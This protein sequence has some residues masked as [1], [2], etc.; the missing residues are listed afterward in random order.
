MMKKNTTLRGMLAAT[1]LTGA[2]LCADEIGHRHVIFGPDTSLDTLKIVSNVERQSHQRDGDGLLVTVVPGPKSTPTL[3]VAPREG[4]WDL[5]AFGHIEAVITN[6]DQEN[7]LRIEMRV[8][9]EGDWREKPWNTEP[10]RVL[11]GKTM[12]VKVI[13]GHQYGFN[14][15]FKLNP[16]AISKIAL[17]IEHP[18]ATRSYRIE[19]IIAGGPAGEVP[20]VD[21]RS[22]RHI[23]P[24][25][26]LL[27]GGG[28]TVN[29]EKQI[30][31]QGNVA[32]ILEK[33]DG[34]QKLEVA[35]DGNGAKSSFV[36]V[37][38]IGAWNL[39]HSTSVDVEITNTGDTPFTP[40]VSLSTNDREE[41][42]DHFSTPSPIQPGDTQTLRINYI[43][44]KTWQGPQ[45][46]L[47]IHAVRRVT[48][49]G[50]RFKSDRVARVAFSFEHS[51]PMRARIES[52]R[53]V[54]VEEPM[55]E[56]VGT[57]PP[58]D[59]DWVM[60][61]NEEFDGDTLNEA[62]WEPMAP[63]WWGEKRI[64]YNSRKNVFLSDGHAILRVEKRPGWQADDPETGH[65]GE[66]A[67]GVLRTYGKWTQRY[68]YFESRMKIP[69]KTALWPAFW[70]MPDRGEEAGEQWRRQ[71]IGNNGME[72]DI[73]EQLSRWGP[74]RYTIAMHWDGYGK[75][76]KATGATV[77]FNP[78][79]CG[80]ITS[81]LL[82]LPGL[83][84]YYVNG[85]EV[86][87][88]EHER[89]S[90]I[91]SEIIFT[92]PVGGWDNEK[93]PVDAELPADFL[94]DYV[95]VWQLREL[96]E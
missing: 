77:Y 87:R 34:K 12:P 9:N 82:W 73:M 83:A 75:N 62:I 55:P 84:V 72:F 51:A 91:Q 86:A 68:G 43:P 5:S 81:G 58:V 53:A 49:S 44:E 79:P 15:G 18:E 74:Y 7:P 21:P 46:D 45:G 3:F 65:R 41:R 39:N 57:R 78:S 95:R 19:S 37:P 70:L 94:I 23:P 27:G 16:A 28:A 56:W 50:T 32:V 29:P 10:L 66:Y 52:I 76:H 36:L 42:T 1:L 54:V 6:L 89:I 61:L 69:E 64:T 25:G 67:L 59:G 85:R 93:R 40:T 20:P 35:A 96:M 26:Y 63:N 71:D 88:W 90:R 60:T 31:T 24:E 48:D 17:F 38:E 30:Q 92:M 8:D 80:Y 13:F 22:I 2:S 33:V 11:P 47:S 4:V 14:P